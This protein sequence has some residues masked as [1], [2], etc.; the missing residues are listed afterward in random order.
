MLASSSGK[1]DTVIQVAHMLDSPIALGQDRR[2]PSSA[3]DPAPAAHPPAQ[4]RPPRAGPPPP[5]PRERV[6]LG[7]WTLIPL[8]ALLAAAPLRA[9]ASPDLL[10]DFARNRTT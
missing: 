6:P 4:G 10:A 5:A 9:Q 7:R 8:P 2:G 3:R 1:R